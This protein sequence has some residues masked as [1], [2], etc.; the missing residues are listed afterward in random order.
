[1]KVSFQ[2][3]SWN[4]YKAKIQFQFQGFLVLQLVA[5]GFALPQK[6]VEPRQLEP[7]GTCG[8]FFREHFWLD[9]I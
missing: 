1:M 7:R 9:R 3:I 6:P 2:K 8:K 5:L 4:I